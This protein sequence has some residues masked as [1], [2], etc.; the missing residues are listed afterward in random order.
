MSHNIKKAVSLY[1]YSE[2][3]ISQE[4]FTYEDMFRHLH[5]LGI[6]SSR[7]M[8]F[9]HFWPCVKNMTW[10]F[11]AMTATQTTVKSGTMI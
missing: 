6:R 5:G 4:N 7:K 3:W 8:R 1:S 9:R 11:T 10:N 2:Q